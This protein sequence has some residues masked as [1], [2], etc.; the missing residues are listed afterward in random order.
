MHNGF[1][2]LFLLWGEIMA[3]IRGV[4]YPDSAK[5]RYIFLKTLEEDNSALYLSAISELNLINGENSKDFQDKMVFAFSF[6][7]TAIQNEKIKENNFFR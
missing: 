5:S 2:L 7:K 1:S 3:R 6:L 4:W